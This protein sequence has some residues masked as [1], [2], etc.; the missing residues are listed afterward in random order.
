MLEAGAVNVLITQPHGAHAFPYIVA[1]VS[2]TCLRIAHVRTM[3]EAT[4]LQREWW[5]SY[6][7][8]QAGELRHFSLSAQIE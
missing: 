8:I 7:T 6:Y 5:N 2:S 4:H 1:E 3:Q